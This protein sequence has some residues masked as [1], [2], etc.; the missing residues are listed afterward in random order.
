LEYPISR[1]V[2]KLKSDYVFKSTSIP[3]V[4][5]LISNIES[6]TG[7]KN[8]F[9]F[10]S[11]QVLEFSFENEDAL[12]NKNIRWEVFADIY[13]TTYLYCNK[14][15]SYAYFKVNTD[16]L[17]FTGFKGDKKSELYYFYLG[18]YRVIFGFYKNIELK[19]PLPIEVSRNK[20]LR[21]V[22][23][24]VAP[25]YR[26][27]KPM[28]RMYYEKIE[29]VFDDSKIILRSEVTDAIGQ[30]SQLLFTNIFDVD[31]KGIN[32]WQIEIEGRIIK[33]RRVVD[34]D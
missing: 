28:F 23:D 31:S 15:K 10:I 8:A 5:N 25:F 4:G 21:P 16:E 29:E 3:E 24:F 22:Q 6:K 18:A 20:L 7:L 11:G 13:N 12:F 1:Y 17:I 9:S 26:F 14:S 2:Q 19:D 34:E 30:K 32:N 33:Y 27:M